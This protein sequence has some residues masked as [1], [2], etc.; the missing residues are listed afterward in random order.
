MAAQFFYPQTLFKVSQAVVNMVKAFSI[1]REN[2]G[3]FA[4][5]PRFGLTARA[6]NKGQEPVLS[7]LPP[8][9]A[10][11]INIEEI[12]CDETQVGSITNQRDWILTAD[13]VVP[14][15]L[16]TKRR[17]VQMVFDYPPLPVTIHYSINIFVASGDDAAQLI[18]QIYPRFAIPNSTMRIRPFDFLDTEHPLVVKC[19]RCV[20]NQENLNNPANGFV[21]VETLFDIKTQMMYPVTA[22]APIKI[23]E[24]DLVTNEKLILTKSFNELDLPLNLIYEK[25]MI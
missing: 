3:L 7:A 11:L 13:L 16:G 8:L 4:I 12:E 20:I 23:V 1:K 10:A 24:L 9:P 5:T 2:Q 17:T 22:D 21:I 14:E 6:L 19:T 15:D 18:E 25:S